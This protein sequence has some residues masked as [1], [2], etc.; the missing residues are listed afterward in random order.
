M[1][2]RLS[3][4]AN[5]AVSDC[6]KYEVRRSHDQT[7]GDFYNAWYLPANKHIEASHHKKDVREG[8]ERHAAKMAEVTA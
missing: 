1:K 6:G 3:S 5:V 2:W 8:C 4:R 7:R